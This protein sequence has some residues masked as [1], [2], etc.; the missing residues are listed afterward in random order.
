LASPTFTGTP[1]STTAAVDTNTTQIATTAYVIGQGYAKTAS[2]SFSGTPSLP[3]GTIAV[4]QTAGNNTTAVATTAF[5]TAAVPAFATTTEA[6]TGTSSTTAISPLLMR[7]LMS[8]AGYT[9]YSSLV[10]NYSTY[11]SG[12]T[13]LTIYS[14]YFS[15]YAQGISGKVA[16]CPSSTANVNSFQSRGTVELAL[17]WS[18]PM[19]F[20]FRFHFPSSLIGD[21]TTICRV[22]V[23]KT[24]ST[25]GDLS[26]SGFGVKW[27]GGT[28]GAFTI[29]A[30][31]GTSL[32]TSASAVT[33]SNTTYFPSTIS[34]A[35]FLVYS[36]GAGNITLFCNNVQVATTTG[37]PSSGTTVQGRFA[38]ETDNSTSFTQTCAP[39][40]MGVRS[41]LAY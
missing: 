10:G 31:N 26:V 12:N 16:L 21:A 11:Q 28:S 15:P 5:V 20:S 25:F 8:N 27:T 19:W 1:L 38:F 6:L 23:G 7:H 17:N 13:G 4:T 29:M 32:T 22:S 37:G 35:D 14:D 24:A 34:T 9:T 18:K 40:Y 30:H 36:D 3:T 2:P 41:L 33:V 39:T